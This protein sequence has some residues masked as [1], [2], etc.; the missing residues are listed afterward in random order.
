MSKASPS[1]PDNLVFDD[2]ADFFF[3]PDTAAEDTAANV[4][5]GLIGFFTRLP[6]FDDVLS[7]LRLM[8]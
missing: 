1:Q 6:S 3:C 5:G 2:I 7:P 4:G 8:V